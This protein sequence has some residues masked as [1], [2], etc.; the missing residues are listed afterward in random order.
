VSHKHN[1]PFVEAKEAAFGLLKFR[2]RTEKELYDRLKK[3]KLDEVV[4]TAT[5]AFLKEKR[6][7]NDD[8]FAKA[9]IESR[10]KK[11]LGLRRLK[12][13]LKRKGVAPQIIARYLDEVRTDYRED[14]VVSDIIRQRTSMLKGIDPLKAKR[15][16]YAYLLRRGFSPD[17][18][19][20]CL[21]RLRTS[22]DHP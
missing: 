11:P 2:P 1:D 5:I 19:I 6:F 20:D 22:T 18:V 13:E 15:R 16:L 14:I 8:D 7:V 9:W 3:K 4:I 21:E 17:I 10:I 12:E